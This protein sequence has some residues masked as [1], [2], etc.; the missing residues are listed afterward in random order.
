MY[1]VTATVETPSGTP[2]ANIAFTSMVDGTEGTEATAADGSITIGNLPSGA[3]ITVTP[4]LSS[5]YTFTPPQYQSAVDGNLSVPFTATTYEL[6]GQVLTDAAENN[7]N[8]NVAGA[9]VELNGGFATGVTSPQTVQ[10]DLY[11]SYAFSN[12]IRGNT[13]QYT[14]SKTGWMTVTGSVVV[15]YPS[16][17]NPLVYN[18]PLGQEQNGSAD[19]TWEWA[20]AFAL[21]SLVGILGVGTGV[22]TLGATFATVVIQIRELMQGAA[23]QADAVATVNSSAVA[24]AFAGGPQATFAEMA[25]DPVGPGANAMADAVADSASELAAESGASVAESVGAVPAAQFSAAEFLQMLN[26]MPSAVRGGL[27]EE[28][29]L[30]D[31]DWLTNV[32]SIADQYKGI[33]WDGPT[34][35]GFDSAAFAEA[36][37]LGNAAAT[38]AADGTGYAIVEGSGEAFS[39]ILG[40]AVEDTLVQTCLVALDTLLLAAV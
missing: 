19:P 23:S 5:Y 14:V 31:P 38:A 20:A 9:T 40:G 12:L 29:L 10:T 3:Q 2:L 13:Y 6:M 1:T 32:Q 33:L 21:S 39:E 4:D 24:D 34:A 36:A 26:A 18:I 30:S 15:S 25:A 22:L 7:N 8:P 17:S 11:G 35:E 27:L 37:D 16:T 28:N